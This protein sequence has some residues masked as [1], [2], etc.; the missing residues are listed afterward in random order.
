MQVATAV[1]ELAGRVSP[2]VEEAQQLTILVSE[3]LD[4]LESLIETGFG[5]STITKN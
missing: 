4:I 1:V 2:L 5:D 3:H